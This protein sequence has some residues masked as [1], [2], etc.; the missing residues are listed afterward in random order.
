MPTPETVT[1]AIGPL[2]AG[3]IA[4]TIATGATVGIDA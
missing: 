1:A 4:R 3:K 2:S